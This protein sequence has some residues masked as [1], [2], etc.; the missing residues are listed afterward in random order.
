MNIKY[1]YQITGPEKLAKLLQYYNSIEV[2]KDNSGNVKLNLT[3]EMNTFYK[4]YNIIVY[5]Q[6]IMINEMFGNQKQLNIFKDVL[7]NPKLAI[8]HLQ[9]R[10]Y[11]HDDV[12]RWS[13]KT[14]LV[15]L[16]KFVSVG[17]VKK[18]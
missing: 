4:T 6:H 9:D 17:I 7:D 11:N 12:K 1:Q 2:H 3:I 10:F 13:L 5:Y 14:F 15:N 8:L 16:I 18:A